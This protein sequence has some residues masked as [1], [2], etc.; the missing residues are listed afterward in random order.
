MGL[1][2]RGH[3]DIF[4]VILDC[5]HDESMSSLGRASLSVI[6]TFFFVKITTNLN[7]EG[8]GLKSHLLCSMCSKHADEN[9]TLQNTQGGNHHEISRI[10]SKAY[11]FPSFHTADSDLNSCY[12]FRIWCLI[13]ITIVV[14]SVCLGH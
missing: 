4:V 12:I 6:H 10:A 7:K 9:R 5:L 3:S 13:L 11:T 14:T 2:S 1:V 8:E